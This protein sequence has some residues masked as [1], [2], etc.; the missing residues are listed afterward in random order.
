[1]KDTRGESMI[2][3]K[4]VLHMIVGLIE[5][6]DYSLIEKGSILTN[7]VC[8]ESDIE[9]IK[10]LAALIKDLLSTFDYAS[11]IE[12]LSLLDG[13][14]ES[15]KSM[16]LNSVNKPTNKQK[17]LSLF[18]EAICDLEDGERVDQL[19]SEESKKTLDKARGLLES[20]NN[21]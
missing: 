11:S 21:P 4:Q 6:S 7:D 12:F 5:V 1:M 17:Y 3:K 9:K 13:K 14:S 20:I 2:S 15:Y 19:I 8:A 10:E 18:G 16:K